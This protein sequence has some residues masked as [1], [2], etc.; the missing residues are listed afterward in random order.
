MRRTVLAAVFALLGGH[1]AVAGRLPPPVCAQPAVLERVG[2]ILRH[3]GRPMRL[4]PS[5]IGEV[6]TGPG[7]LVYCAVRGQA[8]A[9]D[10]NRYA[11]LPVEQRLVIR[12]TLELRRNGIFVGVE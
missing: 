4:D 3:A 5:P 6:S 10:T 7:A 9:Y 11:M 8:L 12:Y 2:E 1:A